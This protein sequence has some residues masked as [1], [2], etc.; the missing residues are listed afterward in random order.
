MEQRINWPFTQAVHITKKQRWRFLIKRMKNSNRLRCGQCDVILNSTNHFEIRS[1]LF[2]CF[3]WSSIRSSN[4]NKNSSI[5][6]KMACFYLNLHFGF[7]QKHSATDFTE[8]GL[9]IKMIP[10]SCHFWSIRM[11]LKNSPN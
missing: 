4:G 1:D 11:N 8:K 2:A 6:H 5:Q 3:F 9:Q 10:T 7:W